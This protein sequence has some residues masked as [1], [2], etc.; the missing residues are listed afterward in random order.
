MI[1]RTLLNFWLDV[2]LLLVFSLLGWV[3][4]VLQFVFPVGTQAAGWVLWGWDYIAWRN[5]QFAVLCAMAMA[6]LLHVMLHWTWV[7]GVVFSQ[8]IAQKDRPDDG[9]R[10]LYG[11]GLLIVLLNI[12]GIGFAAAHVMIDGPPL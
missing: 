2:L 12:L 8:L 4:A 6:V 1:S 3:S 7:C 11:V 9:L 5:F 10:T